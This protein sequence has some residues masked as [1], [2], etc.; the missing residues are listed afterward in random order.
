MEIVLRM[1]IYGAAMKNNFYPLRT[2]VGPS[3]PIKAVL[4]IE[5]QGGAARFAVKEHSGLDT[6]VQDDL[7]SKYLPDLV[8]D[9]DRYRPLP[10]MNTMPLYDSN[11][12]P[13]EALQLAN[14]ALLFEEASDYPFPAT[15]PVISLFHYQDS[16]FDVLD[17]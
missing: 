3:I 7:Y 9:S 16:E 1:D 15:D 12:D 4:L 17:S 11:V 13:L 5:G 6:T 8:I 10:G 2:V 14:S